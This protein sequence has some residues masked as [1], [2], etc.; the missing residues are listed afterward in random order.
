MI[1]KVDRLRFEFPDGWIASQYDDWSFYRNQFIRVRDGIK[2]VDIVAVD[3]AGT[4][5]FIEA[6]DY[7]RQRRTKT[8]DLADEVAQKICDTLAALLPARLNA[9]DSE[10][11][12]MAGALLRAKRLRVVLHLEQPRRHSKLFPRAIDPAAVLQ[13]L[14]SSVRAIDPRP[15]VVEREKMGR[16]RWVVQ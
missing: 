12:E 16:L 2:A 14:R 13:K 3:D 8:I 9:N 4:A 11:C 15:L 5:W 1:L 6:K 10:E 7:R